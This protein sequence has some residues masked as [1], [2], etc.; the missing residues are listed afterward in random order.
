MSGGVRFRSKRSA[1]TRPPNPSRSCVAL[2]LVVGIVTAACG[3]G[4]TP[5]DAQT[6]EPVATTDAADLWTRIDVPDPG[7][8][9]TDIAST[10][11]GV[12]I[13]GPAGPAAQLARAWNSPDG[14]AWAVDQLP[15]DGRTPSLLVPWTDRVVAIGAGVSN[16][17][18]HPAALDTWLRTSDGAWQE[19]PWADLFCAGGSPSAAAASDHVVVAGSG[20]GDVPF[21]WYSDDALRWTDIPVPPDIGFPRAVA[22]L[23]ETDVLM[24]T[25]PGNAVWVSSSRGGVTWSTPTPLGGPAADVLGMVSLDGMFV[26]ILRTG[27]GVVGAYVSADGVSWTSAQALGIDGPQIGRIVAIEGG[28]VALGADDSGPKLWVSTDGKSWRVVMVPRETGV[29]GSLQGVTVSG[30]RVFVVGQAS[31]ETEAVGAAWMAPVS[32]VA[33]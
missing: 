22:S 25:S 14:L 5:S 33:P 31:S 23:G 15:G 2:L 12:V 4:P 26:A 19:A 17:C 11:S 7:A 21:L 29:T 32:L 16:R 18:A 6:A 13:V 9:F 24:G 1:V 3:P 8:I 10:A 30:G 27:A 28:L 20:T